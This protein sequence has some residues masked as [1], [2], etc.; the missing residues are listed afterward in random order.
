[1]LESL[2]CFSRIAREAHAPLLTLQTSMLGTE[3]LGFVNPN[4]RTSGLGNLNLLN[5][6]PGGLAGCSGP[7]HVH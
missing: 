3:G 1:M 7:Y 4:M 2:D 6:R 5:G